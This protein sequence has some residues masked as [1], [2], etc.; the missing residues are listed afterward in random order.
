[1]KD[2]SAAPTASVSA[3]GEKSTTATQPTSFW[4]PT[5]HLFYPTM[6][7]AKWKTYR[8]SANKFEVSYPADWSFDAGKQGTVFIDNEIVAWDLKTYSINDLAKGSSYIGSRQWPTVAACGASDDLCAQK[9]E[10]DTYTVFGFPLTKYVQYV[11]RTNQVYMAEFLL[12]QSDMTKPG[13]GWIDPIPQEYPG[14]LGK[15]DKTK[16]YVL[17]YQMLPRFSSLKISS[18]N[19]FKEGINPYMTTLDA[20]TRSLKVIK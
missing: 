17:N 7:V 8:D 2:L 18:V 4:Y 15:V 10:E 16:Y 3:S 11:R 9:E 12:K 1:M 13:F 19:D 20:I 6:A 14:L 5:P